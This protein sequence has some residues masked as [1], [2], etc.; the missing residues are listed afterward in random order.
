VPGTGFPWPAAANP[1]G[2]WGSRKRGK[3]REKANWIVQSLGG[4]VAAW[5]GCES[6]SCR[7]R[8]KPRFW[9]WPSESSC[10]ILLNVLRN[11]WL[12]ACA[13]SK[14]GLQPLAVRVL[15][16]NLV[17]FRDSNQYPQA[18]LDR[19]CHRGVRL[20]LGKVVDG[21]LACG[22]YG[23]QYNGLGKCVHIPSLVTGRHIPEGFQVPSFRCFERDSYIWVWM[24]DGERI[25]R[26]PTR[27]MGSIRHAWLQGSIS[28]Q[29]DVMKLIEN[30]VDWCHP[31]FTHEGTHPAYFR[32]KA[33]GFTEYQFEVRLTERDFVMLFP[34]TSRADEPISDS[35]PV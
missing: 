17:I 15:D 8:P 4:A 20:S 21:T 7:S 22:Y 16:Q 32:L 29:C 25:R 1:C 6:P 5:L 28:Y 30:N 34:P 27:S 9:G 26:N 35:P 10:G 14:L 33:V 11:Y 31:G 3:E 12:I 13:S 23:W 19:C 24:G 2:A 18:L